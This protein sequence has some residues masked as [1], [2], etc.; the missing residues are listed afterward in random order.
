MVPANRYRLGDRCI[1][2]VR[3]S[4]EATFY[5]RWCEAGRRERCFW[6]IPARARNASFASPELGNAAATSG[7]RTTTALPLMYRDAYLLG[8]ARL[9][10][11]SGRI[12]SASTWLTAAPLLGDFFMVPSFMAGCRPRADDAN[13]PAPFSIHH[14]A[15]TGGLRKA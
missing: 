15:Q 3:N 14:R 12:S 7:S 11:Y 13:R 9:K 10:S 1:R 6:M 4:R 8:A 2:N 5:D